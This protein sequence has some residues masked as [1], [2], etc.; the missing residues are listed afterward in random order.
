[1]E[2]TWKAAYRCPACSYSNE[3]NANFYQARGE[4]KSREPTQGT[5]PHADMPLMNLKALTEFQE[6]LRNKRYERR[7]DP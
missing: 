6:S 4:P 7:K 5:P 2:S 3:S 1:M